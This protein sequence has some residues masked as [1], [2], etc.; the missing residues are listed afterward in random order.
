MAELAPSKE[1]PPSQDFSR[2]IDA[3]VAAINNAREVRA[4]QAQAAALGAAAAVEPVRAVEAPVPS[5]PNDALQDFW[6]TLWHVDVYKDH[7]NDY[8][9]KIINNF[10]PNG[11]VYTTTQKYNDKDI[12]K[13]GI[14]ANRNLGKNIEFEDLL[15]YLTGKNYTKLSNLP[16][17]SI[18]NAQL[19]STLLGP[20]VSYDIKIFDRN[21]NNM[22]EFIQGDKVAMYI[23][24]ASHIPEMMSTFRSQNNGNTLTYAY[25]REIESDPADK[26]TYQT[27]NKNIKNKDNQYSFYYEMTAP[28]NP[29][30]IPYTS[31][32]PN[33]DMSYFYCK[34][35][36]FLEY[37]GPTDKPGI[38]LNKRNYKLNVKLSYNRDGKQIRIE[39]GMNIAGAAKNALFKLG[40]IETPALYK[41]MIFISKH[42]G[43]VA[44]SLVKFRN[45]KMINP[46]EEERAKRAKE[47]GEAGIEPAIINT[48]DYKGA[49][50][51]IDVNAIIKALTIQMPYIFMYPPDK[52]SIIVWK[53]VT[54]ITPLDR[55]NYQL[56]Y[57]RKK[58]DEYKK[59]INEYNDKVDKLNN[60]LE[61]YNNKLIESFNEE[62]GGNLN[63]LINQ[64][65]EVIKK[66]FTLA[67][68]S[69]YIPN[70]RLDKYIDRIED[71]EYIKML[72]DNLINEDPLNNI[73]KIK[74]FQDKIN[75]ASSFEFP[76]E[77]GN[78]DMFDDNGNITVKVAVEKEVALSFKR[79]GNKYTFKKSNGMKDIWEYI[80]FNF[81]VGKG[82]GEIPES[83]ECR[84]GT[85][86]NSSWGIDIIYYIYTE[87]KKYK[88]RSSTDRAKNS[89]IDNKF[90]LCLH[91]IV[92][93]LNDVDKINTFKFGLSL[94]GIQGPVAG[95]MQRISIQ[96][97]ASSY[98]ENLLQE[99]I[100]IKNHLEEM[101]VLAY[102]NNKDDIINVLN[103]NLNYNYNKWIVTNRYTIED[104]NAIDEDSDNYNYY[105]FYS[106]IQYYNHIVNF[107]TNIDN[108]DIQ[109]ILISINE[110]ITNFDI[111][112]W[113][114]SIVDS[115]PIEIVNRKVEQANSWYM[116]M[117]VAWAADQA[118]ISIAS[119][120]MAKRLNTTRKR[121]IIKQQKEELL[122][123][124]QRQRQLKI[125]E[126]RS[127]EQQQEQPMMEMELESSNEMEKWHQYRRGGS[128]LLRKYNKNKTQ[129]KRKLQKKHKTQK[130][131][132]KK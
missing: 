31:F 103:Y 117:K 56:E 54:N 87:L 124:R 68:L 119:K 21:G 112:L 39:E 47:K 72:D 100:N 22:G 76:K 52:K 41:E 95:G 106:I 33:D 9:A 132:T 75:E 58:F 46:N 4:A 105:I 48:N 71:N 10:L 30:I 81:I 2:A 85:K 60:N 114:Y 91:K 121:A 13:D 126:R 89:N 116:K 120:R 14:E 63:D 98:N 53:N 55:Y 77:Y 83:I 97:S 62:A 23:D 43:D 131:H 66:G 113:E 32:T 5:L 109:P 1:L 74:E 107:F 11:G 34:W 88:E 19:N 102:R 99:L 123:R 65:K 110:L 67:V 129:K 111:D 6:K 108:K 127:L 92:N 16:V 3:M 24:T 64:Y 44:Q 17:G 78:L 37:N 59:N 29:T 82:R 80:D 122:R 26:I 57:T 70:K 28:N 79:V 18:D 40:G 130:K 104:L 69:K 36:L 101:Y 94:V 45:V 96:P 90:S 8:N 73:D 49:F 38:P 27:I 20:G 35:P 12:T 118:S 86:L 115:Y 25:T 128:N 84:S 93:Q 50:V 125:T 61:N 7:K 15:E 51:S 42:H